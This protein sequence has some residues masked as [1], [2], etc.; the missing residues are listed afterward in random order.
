[1]TDDAAFNP[2]QRPRGSGLVRAIGLFK[3]VKAIFLIAAA[4]SVFK[5]MHRD[6]GDVVLTWAHRFH[7]APG[8]VL[9]ERLLEKVLTV[10]GHQLIVVGCVLLSYAAMFL[11]EGIGLLLLK[12]WAEWMTVITTSGLI[13]IEMYEIIRHPTWLKAIA[14]V[15]NII[16]AVYL[17]VHVRR[18]GIA[19]KHLRQ[20]SPN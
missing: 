12:H 20:L 3:L 6:I 10:T 7:I 8:N 19:A 9:L 1:M 11:V 16:L 13:P 18:E 15:I 14:M 2:P 5:L 4:I 17:A